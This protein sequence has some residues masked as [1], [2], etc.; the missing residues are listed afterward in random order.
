MEYFGENLSLFTGLK[1]LDLPVE[2]HSTFPFDGIVISSLAQG[3]KSANL[4]RI[5]PVPSP[6]PK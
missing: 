3:Y 2:R 4:S 5:S 6:P 1:N